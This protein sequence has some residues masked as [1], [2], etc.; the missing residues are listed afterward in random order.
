MAQIIFVFDFEVFGV[1]FKRKIKKMPQS[2][3]CHNLT[4]RAR[5]NRDN[6]FVL[7]HFMHYGLTT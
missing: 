7:F 5:T 1:V 3:S 6:H 4:F 2:C